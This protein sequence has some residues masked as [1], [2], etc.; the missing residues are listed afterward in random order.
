MQKIKVKQKVKQ[1]AEPKAEPKTEK[2]V[3]KGLLILTNGTMSDITMSE[4]LKQYDY[5]D[6][7]SCFHMEKHG[8]H[9]AMFLG[10]Q[11]IGKVVKKKSTSK[12]N[13][14]ATMITGGY[15]YS[16]VILF[17][18]YKPIDK[19]TVLLLLQI[20]VSIILNLKK[21]PTSKFDMD[22]LKNKK[23]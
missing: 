20:G 6:T 4:F 3:Q 11:K 10:V 16:D 19:K 8:F 18:D 1:K 23:K 21:I 22:Q 13:M 7:C 2:K 5:S 12:E 14:A 9:L 15:V 17:D